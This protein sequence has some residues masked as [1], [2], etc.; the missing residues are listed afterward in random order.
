MPLGRRITA[1]KIS[2][3][4]MTCLPRNVRLLQ[5]PATPSR[6]K[7]YNNS[8]RSSTTS[9]IRN[10][11]NAK[12]QQ[13]EQKHAQ[14][15]QQLQQRHTQQTQQMQQRSAPASHAAPSGGGKPKKFGL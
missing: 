4:R 12:T 13:L 3:I 6:I 1:P 10:A 8:S 15:T 5:T 11:R 9:R 2:L 7:K 14:Q